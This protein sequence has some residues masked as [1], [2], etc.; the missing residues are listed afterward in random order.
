MKKLTREEQKD[1]AYVAFE[2]ISNSAWKAYEARVVSAW[3]AYDARCKEIEEQV[4]E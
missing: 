3:R 4:E 1:E 2:A